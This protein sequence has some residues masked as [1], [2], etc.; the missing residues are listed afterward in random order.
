MN[1]KDYLKK[2]P[3][4]DYQYFD[5][6]AAVNSIKA[7][8]YARMAYCA[9]V[10]AENL[11]RKCPSEDLQASLEQLV[12][13]KNEL[14]FPWF[15]ARVVCHDILGQTAFVDLA[16]LRDA[17]ALEG[18]DPR[19]VN[20]KVP[21][22]LIVDH[23]LAVEHAGFEDGAFAKNRAIE[24][25]R[26]DD[27][28]DFID[29]CQHAFDNVNVVPPG[30]GIMHQINLEKMSPVVH[31]EDG[32]A[33]PDTLV[34]TDSHT[35]MVDALGVISIGVGGLE[36]ESVMLGRPTYMRR[37]EF[38]GVELTGKLS[39]GITGTDLVLALTAFLRDNQVVG[40]YL[41]FF[42]AGASSLSVGDRASISNM[43]PEY[44]A[45]AGMFSIDEQTLTY[46]RLTGRSDDQVDLV[47]KYAKASGLWSS[48]MSQAVYSRTLSFDLG[49]VVRTMAG[50]SKPH[51]QLPVSDLQTRGIAQEGFH[52]PEDGSMPDGAVIIAAITSCTNTSNPRNMIGAGL[53]ARNAAKLGL[54]RKPWVKTS[55]APGSKTVS[56]YLQEAGLM[57]DLK[58]LGFDVVAYA[59]TTCNGMS[60]ALDP[61]IQQE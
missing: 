41:E 40:A 20:P 44:G 26:N 5:T 42:G 11:L 34:G 16:G 4:T 17:I 23:S 61:V 36:A 47:E 58:T 27:R 15:P 43:T 55:L 48:A 18:G 33:F 30:N 8:E 39:E 25:R 59:C 19:A 12:L 46:L 22:Q 32:V 10:H 1:A 38:V 13:R 60:G 21:T 31:V 29:W 57:D 9:K 24:N 37:P 54:T 14:D 49:A 50:P 7:G 6:E 28:F 52:L 2:L 51:A 45:T 35:P 56:L 3:G 53:I